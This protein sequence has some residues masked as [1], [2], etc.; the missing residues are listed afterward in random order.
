[1][2]KIGFPVDPSGWASKFEPSSFT[3]GN[4]NKHGG[5]AVMMDAFEL[6]MHRWQ[7]RAWNVMS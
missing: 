2:H 7:F 3:N 5:L 4:Q 6:F 1:M